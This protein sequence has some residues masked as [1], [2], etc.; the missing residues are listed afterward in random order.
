MKI[1]RVVRKD[2]KNVLVHFDNNQILILSEDIYIKSGLKKNDEFSED[3][4]LSLI[5]E[6]RLFHIKQRA[7]RYLG[8]RLHSTSELRVKLLQKKYEKEL[9]EGV[10]TELKQKK[11]LDD[12][13]FAKMFV[14]EKV[15]QKLWGRK[16]LINEL[17]KRGIDS[18]IISSVMVSSFPEDDNYENAK[19]LAKKKYDTLKKRNLDQ[20]KVRSKLKT[21]LNSRGY[22][23]DIIKKV[24]DELIEPDNDYS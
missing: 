10:L 8:R 1:E 20:N 7:F 3:R 22:D 18:K 9:V 13:E 24:V 4:F 19:Q 11:Y 16:K 5:R 2:A 12:T 15:K 21:F 14:E 6:N 17:V 23:Y